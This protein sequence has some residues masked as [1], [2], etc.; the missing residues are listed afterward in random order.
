MVDIT[1]VSWADDG[2][3]RV[4]AVDVAAM[5]SALVVNRSAVPGDCA[6]VRWCV[7][8]DVNG[9]GR[10]SRGDVGV[11]LVHF[12]R[13]GDGERIGPPAT[14]ASAFLVYAIDGDRACRIP[15]TTPPP[16]GAGGTVE[17]GPT[18]V[19]FRVARN[20]APLLGRIT[21]RTPVRCDTW[22]TDGVVWAAD[23]VPDTIP[24]AVI[25][26]SG[27]GTHECEEGEGEDAQ[28]SGSISSGT[29]R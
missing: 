4:I 6:E 27:A 16:G 26:T 14:V 19:I 17:V 18:R 8:F 22:W 12:R 3:A 13:D 15:L 23:S 21:A 2:T 20:A 25:T 10:Y 11:E 7:R 24:D 1:G 9:D 5:P 29:V 28:P